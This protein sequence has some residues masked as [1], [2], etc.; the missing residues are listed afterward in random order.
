MLQADIL[1]MSNSELDA[2]YAKAFDAKNVKEYTPL[3]MEILDRLQNFG[4]FVTGWFGV[5]K[6]PMYDARGY[7]KQVTVAQTAVKESAANVAD[8][9]TFGFK[10]AIALIVF[11]GVVVL[12]WKLKK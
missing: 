4:A 10:G 9:I 7:F 5:K 12:V 1:K 8:N 3:A 2:A 11:L 6:F